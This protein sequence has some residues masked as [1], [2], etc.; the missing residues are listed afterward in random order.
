MNGS[1]RRDPA[2][3]RRLT[4]WAIGA[5]LVIRA[6]IAA[7][8]PLLPDEAY[9][10]EWSRHL[11]A[12]YFDHPPAVAWL[13]AAGTSLL[14]ATPLG[15]RLGTLLAG[16]GAIAGVVAI[17]RRLGGED[18]ALRAAILLLCTP[19]VSVGLAIATT[20]APALLAIATALLCIVR[21]LEHPAGTRDSTVWWLAAG[22]AFGGGL[23]SKLTVGIVGAACG[24]ALLARPSL[25]RQLRSAGPWLA[26]ICTVLVAT[27]V[28]WW[29]ARHDWLAV[30]FQLS[31]GLGTPT[32]GTVLSRE[33]S[34]IGSQAGLLSPGIFLLAIASA[35]HVLRRRQTDA[36]RDVADTEF[37]LAIVG[38]IVFAFF[39]YSALR[40]PVE[41]NWPAPAFVALIPLVAAASVPV[42]MRWWRAAAAIGAALVAA[43][44]AQ[45]VAPVLPIPARR[46]PVARAYGWSTLAMSAD[47]LQRASIATGGTI[48]FA[49]DRYQDAAELAFTIPGNPRVFALNLGGRRNQYD[50]WPSFAA[51]ARRGDAM[52]VALDTGIAEAD[53]SRTLATH[54]DSGRRAASVALTRGADTVAVRRLWVF[55]GWRGT[56]PPRKSPGG[57]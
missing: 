17:A 35:W 47:S 4:L 1:S 22:I 41:A 48:W 30:R 23:L 5:G 33:L 15:V 54:F 55:S 57:G 12:G 45:L 16:T 11:A 29:N 10:W 56:W 18:A 28:I 50:L 6:L 2:S 32:R 3:A 20:D 9:Y 49:A 27:P 37:L 51:V 7:R 19:L 25:R 38:A 24:V 40:R 42:L 53:V 21:A 43:A 39:V 34:L 14:G 36:R 31:H 44:L 8:S 26:V 46:D 13:I 52:I